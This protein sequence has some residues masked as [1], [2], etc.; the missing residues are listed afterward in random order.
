MLGDAVQHAGGRQAVLGA[1]FDGP[2]IDARAVRSDLPRSQQGLVFQGLTKE[3]RG[4]V[5][6]A[7]G[8]Q[9][10]IDRNAVL[11]DGAVEIAYSPR[12]FT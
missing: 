7:F 6:V 1:V 2:G 3:P 10:K 8:G 11:V 5:E 4:G 12:I 9:Q